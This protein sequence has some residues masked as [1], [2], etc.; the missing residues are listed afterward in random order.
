MMYIGEVAKKTGLSIKAIRFYEQ[1]G[2]IR[3]P[4]RAGRYRV[5]NSSDV[6][7][8]IL[9]REAKQLGVTL[10]QLKGVVY[11]KDDQVDWVKISVFMEQV[12]AQLLEQIEAL[13]GKVAKIDQCCEQINHLKG[14]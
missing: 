2:L 9:I 3:E 14:D 6:E 1:K 10:S 8:L 13:R 5:Y 4:D 12:K 11:Y 7:L